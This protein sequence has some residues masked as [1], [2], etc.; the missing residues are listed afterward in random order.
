MAFHFNN[1]ALCWCHLDYF[2]PLTPLRTPPPA[3]A[4]YYT[5]FHL[6]SL[7]FM[8]MAPPRPSLAY[9]GASIYILLLFLHLT[10]FFPPSLVAL[11]TDVAFI[12]LITKC[13][14]LLSV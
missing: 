10:P 9:F 12:M 2:L 11:K 6:S 1:A 3:P 4:R 5:F 14:P 8:I 7:S 13:L